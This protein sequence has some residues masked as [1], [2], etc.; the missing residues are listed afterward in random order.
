MAERYG[1]IRRSDLEDSDFVFP[2]ERSFPV[3]TSKDV[4]DA[5]SSWGRYRGAASFDTFKKRLTALAKRKGFADALPASWD[6]ES[7]TKVQEQTF[8]FDPFSGVKAGKR[9]SSS[10]YA[11]MK[12]MHRDT[13][14]YYTK[15]ATYLLALGVMEE[16]EEG[17]ESVPDEEAMVKKSEDDL[18]EKDDPEPSLTETKALS[19]HTI[20]VMVCQAIHEALDDLD[21]LE[22]EGEDTDDYGRR[23]VMMS[24]PIMESYRKAAAY[25]DEEENDD[26]PVIHV[27]DTYAVVCLGDNKD[28]KV[29]YTIEGGDVVLATPDQWQ[30]VEV[31]WTPVEDA[32]TLN[33]QGEEVKGT[34]V[35]RDE[36]P[37][38]DVAIKM[39][40]DG[41]ILAQAVRFGT[42]SEHDMSSYK[43]FFTKETNFWLDQWDR[44][45][46]LY[47]HAMDE[48]TRDAPVIGTWI[49]AWT[50]DAGVWLQGQLD[51]AHKYYEAIKELARRGLLRVSTDSAPHLVKRE[52]VANG[53]NYVKT[54]PIM[55]ASLTVSPAEP[56]LFPV[57][58]KAQ[59]KELGIDIH[60]EATEAHPPERLERAKERHADA[61]RIAMELDI[62]A[63]EETS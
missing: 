47:H 49:K 63:V 8:A 16:D 22:E 48:G 35:E 9:N 12:A 54:W 50:D 30:L 59:L 14:A 62:L 51:K 29:P 32:P 4:R 44:R 17:E 55:A 26:Y 6:N 60:Q 7:P 25:Y 56:R 31:E 36:T 24:R 41:T 23:L 61:R 13:K 38:M 20:H 42:P 15:M 57:E 52:T 21:L 58:L 40:D 45:P 11:I 39:L 28:W 27:Y 3:M 33:A 2:E 5:V 19:L 1:G 10:D 37:H 46:M 43:D 34:L 18:A 53:V